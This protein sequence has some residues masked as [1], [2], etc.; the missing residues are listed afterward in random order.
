MAVVGLLHLWTRRL[1]LVEQQP[2]LAAPID[3]YTTVL[4]AVMNQPR[5]WDIVRE[6]HWYRIPVKTAPQRGVGAPI[7]A[8]YQTSAFGDEKW[9]IRYF[10]RTTHWDTATRAQ[11]LPEEA[12][13]PRAQEKYY[14][15]HL[16]ELER[17]AHPIPSARWK[18]VT[19]IVTHWARLESA[20]DVSDLLHGTIWEE[21][22]WRA[23][24][25]LGRLAE[26]D[27]FDDW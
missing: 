23:L 7:L 26:E 27:Q 11:L 22:L 18:R 2:T 15:V 1:L 8:F 17:L 13:H 16:G 5:D 24:R 9:A 21:R 14:Q 3:R 4:V 10:G 20:Q 19:F 12:S 25:K 6:K